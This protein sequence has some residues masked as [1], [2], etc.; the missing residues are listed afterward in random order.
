[1]WCHDNSYSC[2][3]YTQSANLLSH[4]L[5][6]TLIVST[7]RSTE[8]N[9]YMLSN[10][11]SNTLLVQY[12]PQ[13]KHCTPFRVISIHLF[14]MTFN[15]IH[16]ILQSIFSSPLDTKAKKTDVFHFFI[17][18]PFQSIPLFLLL[19]RQQDISHHWD[20]K[21]SEPHTIPLLPFPAGAC[22]RA[23]MRFLF[24]LIVI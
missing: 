4:L 9:T 12:T 18:L 14:D 1:M 5:V 23:C 19:S 22:V 16:S 24:F 3:R 2:S 7:G 10:S 11:W 8:W 20:S 21:G 15:F 6:Q 13:I 17:H